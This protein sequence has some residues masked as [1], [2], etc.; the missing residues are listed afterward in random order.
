MTWAIVWYKFYGLYVEF[1]PTFLANAR[2]TSFPA[3]MRMTC[4]ASL[5]IQVLGIFLSNFLLV[6]G[7]D[8]LAQQKAYLGLGL[9]PL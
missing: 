3:R 1:R 6:F 5:V 9:R 8:V 4:S 7:R 2:T